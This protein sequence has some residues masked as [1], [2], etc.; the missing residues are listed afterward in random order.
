[1][2]ELAVCQALLDQ[3]Q[4]VA[5]EHA[6]S[7]VTR[8]TLSIGPLSG[9]V[10][11]LLERAFYIARAGGPASQAA[12][13]TEIPVVRLR[14]RTCGGESDATPARIICAH[15]GDYHIDLLDGDQLVLKRVELSQESTNP[16]T[17][18]AGEQPCVTRADAI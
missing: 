6:N 15:C 5:A 16:M 8:I 18:S 4:A 1:M 3:V 9:V 11:E 17:M 7:T 10:P 12:L 14:C 13:V 2:H